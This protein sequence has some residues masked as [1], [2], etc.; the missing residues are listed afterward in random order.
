MI[1][2]YSF[3]LSVTVTKMVARQDGT[4][5]RY[6]AADREL[7][8]TPLLGSAGSVR[9]T[10]SLYEP[11]GSFEI[12]FSDQMDQPTQDTTYT[13]LEPM[14]LVE[15]RAARSPEQF[16]G[17]DLP[18]VMRGFIDTVRRSES[19]G[20]DGSPRRFIVVTG[21]DF[22]KLLL[23]H[24]VWFELG[25]ARDQPMVT[26]FGL[27]TL[28][29]LSQK[30]ET[31]SD[32]ITEFI[33]VVANARIKAMSEYTEKLV[34][35]FTVEASV[36]DGQILPT[37]IGPLLN[38]SYWQIMNTFADRPWNEFFVI[39]REEG[40]HVIFRP[41]PFKDIY[42]EKLIVRGAKEPG[43]D[44]L[45]IAEVVQLDLERS[46]ARVGNFFWVPPGQSSMITNQFAVSGSIADGSAFDFQ[47]PNN[48]PRIYGER[49][50]DVPTGLLPTDSR[51]VPANLPQDQREPEGLKFVAWYRHRASELQAMNRDNSLFEEGAATV[52]GRE[53][54]EI[55][56]Y[57]QLT[58]G[59][60]SSEFYVTSVSHTI[61]PQNAWTTNIRLER[62]TGF[63]ARLKLNGSPY[64]AEGRSGPYTQ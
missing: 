57:L 46:D 43:M 54:Y 22:A 3:G 32:F 30:L 41:A 52:L 63:L 28:T 29:G 2:L 16:S 45:D 34:P 35:L 39:D 12:S 42:T 6:T 64:A 53:T 11:A 55:G 38:S 23:I 51:G 33:T 17:G 21:H 36:P 50:V 60:L 40:P 27:Q 25:I 26:A 13:L 10:K 48:D 49:R 20:D 62:G 5:K 9:T 4:A 59:D 7:D 61:Q 37:V 56:R 15:I 8:L 31:A 44:V 14:D 19:I 18:L 24:S 1:P 58:R 47:H